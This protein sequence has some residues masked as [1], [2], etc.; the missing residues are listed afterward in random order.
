M[1]KKSMTKDMVQSWELEFRKNAKADKYAIL[2][3]HMSKLNLRGN[4]RLLLEGT[5]RLVQASIAYASI[6]GQ[7]FEEF[8][9]M[10]QYDPA[11]A[12][13]AEYEFTFDIFG[14]A[15]ARVLVP[16]KIGM[17]DLADLYDHPWQDYKICGYDPL[18]ITRIDG[19]YLDSE[20][21]SSLEE[22][23]TMD[24]SSDY[25]EDELFIVFDD[26]TL[27]DTLIVWFH[28]QDGDK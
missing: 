10:Q 6:D 12:V 16:K 7:S 17:P 26:W 14:R 20:E 23:V 4:P 18:Y 19:N 13:N 28:P 1:T 24:M 3:N 21:S 27:E 15:Y 11:K 25:T 5:I 8:L 22:A 2:K 9:I